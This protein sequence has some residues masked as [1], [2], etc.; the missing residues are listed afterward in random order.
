VCVCVCVCVFVFFLIALK[1]QESEL[2]MYFTVYV[3][4][5]SLSPTSF[6][7]QNHRKTLV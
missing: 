5:M 2:K 1:N 4:I 6:E 3:P 7:N